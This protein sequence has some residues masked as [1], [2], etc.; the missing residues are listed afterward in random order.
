M[1]TKIYMYT[2]VAIEIGQLLMFLDRKETL[3]I[4]QVGVGAVFFFSAKARRYEEAVLCHCLPFY[5]TL[6]SG[7]NHSA[8]HLVASSRAERRGKA[9]I[10]VSGFVIWAGTQRTQ[11]CHS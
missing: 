9:R 5:C 1:V 11:K 2:A 10:M 3:F 4:K 7:R 8:F 6:A